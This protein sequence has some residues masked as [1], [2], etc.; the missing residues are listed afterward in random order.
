MCGLLLVFFFVFVRVYACVTL[1]CVNMYVHAY[2]SLRRDAMRPDGYRLVLQLS[3]LCF[4]LALVVLIHTGSKV[5][6]LPCLCPRCQ[7]C[8]C[9]LC[10]TLCGA[11]CPFGCQFAAVVCPTAHTAS[12]LSLCQQC[13]FL[14]HVCPAPWR[15]VTQRVCA[16]AGGSAGGNGRPG[17]SGWRKSAAAGGR[18]E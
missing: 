7:Y 2:Q 12:C 9:P 13:A 18:H 8:D 10:H 4:A 14:P 3:G 5:L 1:V 16:T 17:G 11:Q 6:L 15:Q